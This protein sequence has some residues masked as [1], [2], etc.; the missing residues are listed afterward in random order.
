[1]MKKWTILLAICILLT[2]CGVKTPAKTADG[3]PWD[4][5]WENVGGLIG[6]E[7]MSGWTVSRN[8]GALASEGTYYV[9]WAKGDS[10]SYPNSEGKDITA[11]DNQVYLLATKL[12]TE[13]EA[14]E[15]AA[16]FEQLTDE[17]YP[18]SV[19]ASEELAGQTFSVSSYDFPA[20]QYQLHG[21]SANAVRGSWVIHVDVITRNEDAQAVLE[22]FWNHCHWAA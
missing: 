6:V 16:L 17:R 21:A 1:M 4:R 22:D 13:A 5:N 3:S 11:Y 7:P 18:D 20:A 19:K 12:K 2:G 15:N 10:F 9:T 8:G 14:A